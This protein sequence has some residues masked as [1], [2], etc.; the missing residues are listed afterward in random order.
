MRKWLIVFPPISADALCCCARSQ[1]KQTL[2]TMSSLS[3][4]RLT[5]N[6]KEIPSKFHRNHRCRSCVGMIDC[7]LVWS[8]FFSSART[9]EIFPWPF[10]FYT[11]PE[12]EE[13]ERISMMAKKKQFVRTQTETRQKKFVVVAMA[14]RWMM[15]WNK[16]GIKTHDE[17][18]KREKSLKIRQCTQKW[19]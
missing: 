9:K 17:V 8:F 15:E 7:R 16:G 18:Q 6:K 14:E 3:H 5:K 4:G 2:C 10:T 12:L 19:A 1:F 13:E 11:V